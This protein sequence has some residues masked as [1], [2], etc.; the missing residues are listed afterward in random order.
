MIIYSH[1]VSELPLIHLR[2]DDFLP[3]TTTVNTKNNNYRKSSFQYKLNRV[4]ATQ[5][6]EKGD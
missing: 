5:K 1:V 3:V 6:K 2:G 4:E